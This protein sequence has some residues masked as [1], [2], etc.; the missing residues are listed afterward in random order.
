[1]IHS[2]LFCIRFCQ[3]T[4][5]KHQLF[6]MRFHYRRGILT[7]ELP[8]VYPAPAPFPDLNLTQL[9]NWPDIKIAVVLDHLHFVHEVKQN[10][11][12]S[13]VF[14]D[15][16][17]VGIDIQKNPTATRYL[18]KVK[19]TKTYPMINKEMF[20]TYVTS[21][22]EAAPLYE[23]TSSKLPEIEQTFRKILD[24]VATVPLPSIQSRMTHSRF[25]NE[26]KYTCIFDESSGSTSSNKLKVRLRETI[27][28]EVNFSI[29]KCYFQTDE[30]HVWKNG[31][32]EFFEDIF[33]RRTNHMK[34]SLRDRFKK[35]L[36]LKC[37]PCNEVF[38][39]ALWAVKLKDHIKQKHFVPKKWS[40]VKCRRT[41]DQFELMLAEWKH[42]CTN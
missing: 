41:W 42:E 30:L 21:L 37:E 20:N 19:S 26:Q 33:I 7:A 40:C 11:E 25:L 38:E 22:M 27:N 12:R 14:G 39:G 31:I 35:C 17:L 10:C 29:K 4:G 13:L 16:E 2:I 8:T 28:P 32:P 34:T 36:I 24:D 9:L 18:Q 3:I 5:H 1:M 6:N 15:D 23:I